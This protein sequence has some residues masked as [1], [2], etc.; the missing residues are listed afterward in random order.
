MAAEGEHS[1]AFRKDRDCEQ[2]E[3]WRILLDQVPKVQCGFSL[4]SQAKGQS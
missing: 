3:L 4:N 2:T 1:Q